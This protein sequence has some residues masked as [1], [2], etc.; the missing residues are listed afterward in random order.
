MEN[1]IYK[2]KDKYALY[3]EI[4]VSRNSIGNFDKSKI[5]NTFKTIIKDS[6]NYYIMVNKPNQILK[7]DQQSD[8]V[9]KNGENLLFHIRKTND[10]YQLENLF[11]VFKNM[12][13][14]NL[15]ILNYKL[16]YVIG[17]GYNANN[18]YYL[19]QND[20]IRFGNI[21]LILK[22]IHINN[23]NNANSEKMNYNIYEVN[24]VQSQASYES[25]IEEC[26]INNSEDKCNICKSNKADEDNPLLRL[27][28][29]NIYK[30]F[31]C[32][33]KELENLKK[34]NK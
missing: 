31:N 18:N 5:E 4:K 22:E 8:I 10:G 26:L 17:N 12:T 3:L 24:K 6:C 25:K 27:C 34:K 16:W 23:Y 28:D 11:L 20:I 30:H 29:C 32:L 2:E 1:N 14:D 19:C 15:N 33:K 21:K 13:E 9:L 7:V